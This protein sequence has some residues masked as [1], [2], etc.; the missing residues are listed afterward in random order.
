[1]YIPAWSA[2][3]VDAYTTCPKKYYHLRVAR[4]VQDFPPSEA[5]IAGRELHKAFEN[6]VNLNE[7]LAEKY[8]H[9]NTLLAKIKALPGEKFPEYAMQLDEFHEPCEKRGAWTRGV[10]DL[11]VKRGKEAIIIDYK[12]GKRKPSEQLAL[13]AAYAF[14]YWP[15]LEKVHTMFI[16]LKTKELDKK[17]YTKEDVPMIWQSFL[18]AVARMRNSYETGEWPARPSGLCRAWCPCKGVCKYCGL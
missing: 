8:A 9:L 1:M 6:A 14:A 12:T 17:T 4:D 18:P 10:A 2:S 7:P 5:I 15:E 11:I 13:Y 16:W 3:S